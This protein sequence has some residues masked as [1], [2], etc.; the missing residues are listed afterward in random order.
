MKK[1]LLLTGTIIIMS[2]IMTSCNQVVPLDA[3]VQTMK[4]FGNLSSINITNNS[5]NAWSNVLVT[6][7]EEDGNT[8]YYC[9]KDKILAK[10]TVELSISDFKDNNELSYP[11]DK[12]SV[13]MIKINSDA[14]WWQ[15]DK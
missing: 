15:N 7:K 2:F 12:N 11:S 6:I 9:R 14:G 10:E 4:V 5:S 13:G 1:K 8:E 3:R